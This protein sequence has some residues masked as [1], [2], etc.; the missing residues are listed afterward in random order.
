MS[1]VLEPRLRASTGA[2]ALLFQSYFPGLFAIA[3]FAPA[4]SGCSG[5]EIDQTS[6]LIHPPPNY[7]IS[8]FSGKN[9]Q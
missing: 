4:S 1:S 3:C 2:E 6:S 9:V 7:G 8:G 5:P